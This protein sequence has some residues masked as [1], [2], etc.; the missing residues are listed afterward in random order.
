MDSGIDLTHPDFQDSNGNSRVLFL[1]DQTRDEY[2]PDGYL[3]GT[4]YNNEQINEALRMG[5]P[6]QKMNQ[7]MALLQLGLPAEMAMLL[8]DAIAVLRL[9]LN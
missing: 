8:M 1:W 9:K 7:D 3:F 4:E 6:C 5:K 2:P